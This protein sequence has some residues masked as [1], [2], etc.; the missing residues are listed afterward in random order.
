MKYLKKFN[1][2]SQEVINIISE[3]F[4]DVDMEDMGFKFKISNFGNSLDHRI[5]LTINKDFEK[6]PRIEKEEYGSIHNLLYSK[7]VYLIDI[8]VD[9]VDVIYGT[10]DTEKGKVEI[11]TANEYLGKNGNMIGFLDHLFPTETTILGQIEIIFLDSI[12]PS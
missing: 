9:V 1:E 8:G 3:T 12:Q 5:K 4:S 7:I 11:K 10:I 2:N 6:N